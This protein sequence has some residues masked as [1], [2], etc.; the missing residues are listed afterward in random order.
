MANLDDVVFEFVNAQASEK[1]DGLDAE[2][3]TANVKLQRDTVARIRREKRD[4]ESFVFPAPAR[5]L[6]K[7]LHFL[8]KCEVSA[9]WGSCLVTTDMSEASLI[10]LPPEVTQLHIGPRHKFLWTAGFTGAIVVTTPVVQTCAGICWKFVPMMHLS[11]RVHFTRNFVNS[12]AGIVNILRQLFGKVG[13]HWREVLD[14]KRA[15]VI[16]RDV[17][18]RFCRSMTWFGQ[19]F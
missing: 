16:F 2:V 13:S 5:F 18:V 8:S 10:V 15:G 9:E 3:A 11:R 17:S 1:P 19:W 14:V 4:R 7:H 6:R 12:H